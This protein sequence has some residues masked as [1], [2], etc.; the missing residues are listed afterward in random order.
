MQHTDII[1][2][3]ADA[4]LQNRPGVPEERDPPRPLVS[5]PNFPPQQTAGQ[6]SV[7]SPFRPLTPVYGTA[8][9]PRGLSGLIRKLAYQAPDY[10]P[11]HWMLLML[12]DRVDV[13]EHNIVPATLVV[14]GLALGV[15]GLRALVL[16]R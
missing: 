4:S 10:K 8:V 12:A 1:G 5:I 14:G 13:I 15:F 11:R 7:K 2:W 9:P 16:R 3:G 6:P